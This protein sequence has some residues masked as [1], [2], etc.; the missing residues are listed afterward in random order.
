[1]TASHCYMND[2]YKEAGKRK[3]LQRCTVKPLKNL[4]FSVFR[5]KNLYVGINT[6][7]FMYRLL[8]IKVTVQ[9]MRGNEKY[10]V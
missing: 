2:K 4:Y 1:M 3:T 10:N 7:D 9:Y 6:L 5:G 8:I